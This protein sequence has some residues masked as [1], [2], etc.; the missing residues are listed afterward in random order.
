MRFLSKSVSFLALSLLLLE[1]FARF[2]SWYWGPEVH[3]AYKVTDDG[4]RN[5]L[6]AIGLLELNPKLRIA[7]FG[8]SL[9]H[10]P[11]LALKDRWPVLLQKRGRGHLEIHNFATG[12]S[13]YHSILAMMRKLALR[14]EFF[15]IVLIQAPF[16]NA[17]NP[18]NL[19]N[20]SRNHFSAR[21][22]VPPE[23]VVYL[24]TLLRKGLNRMWEKSDRWGVR[25][26]LSEFKTVDERDQRERVKSGMT[27]Y[28]P[29]FRQS[30][31]VRERLSSIDI[32]PMKEELIERLR[33]PYA[34][35]V[36][37]AKA[38]AN[39][40]YYVPNKL[41]FHPQ[42][43]QSYYEQTVTT[44][45]VVPVADEIKFFDEESHANIF[46][47]RSQVNSNLL[48][49]LGIKTLDYYPLIEELIQH[50]D[51]YTINEFYVSEHSS[52]LLADFFWKQI[53]LPE[54]RGRHEL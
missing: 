16:F 50:H 47:L 5:S 10:H 12:F 31:Y 20:E 41:I 49:E 32:P 29:S 7:L 8:S 9:L 35:L 38:I 36:D 4:H 18:K 39:K 14:G 30:P 51:G 34:E 2:P 44:M 6:G 28:D 26:W 3:Q 1:V 37:E 19:Y 11:H 45:P 42:M 46:K 23:Q 43:L 22:L 54:I 25:E 17:L 27:L 15:D 21:W 53:I 40:I 52:S 48:A 33:G 24:P 13:D